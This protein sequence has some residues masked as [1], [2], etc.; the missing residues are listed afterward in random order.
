MQDNRGK[1]HAVVCLH[2]HAEHPQAHHERGVHNVTPLFGPWAGWRMAGR[3]LVS[4][5]GDRITSRRLIGILWVERSRQRISRSSPP[6]PAR[7]VVL[8][9]RE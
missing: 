8:P 9:A 2:C 6:P 4:P 3:H 5:D 1:I 7:P